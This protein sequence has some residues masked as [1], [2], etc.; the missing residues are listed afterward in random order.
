MLVVSAMSVIK[1]QIDHLLRYAAVDII[2]V[3]SID[4]R[5]G[6]DPQRRLDLRA[7]IYGRLWDEWSASEQQLGLM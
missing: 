1:L 7:V 4:N 2:S 6:G 5:D 3:E